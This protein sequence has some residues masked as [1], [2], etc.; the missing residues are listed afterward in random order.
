MVRC[1][2]CKCLCDPGDLVNGVC[3]DCWEE[4]RQEQEKSE[5]LSKMLDSEHQQ[6][7]MEGI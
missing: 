3:D 6:M 4:E 2:R 1:E 5:K 7:I